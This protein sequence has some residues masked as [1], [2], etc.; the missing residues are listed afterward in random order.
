MIAPI[1][2]I[3]LFPCVIVR[4]IVPHCRR[5]GARRSTNPVGETLIERG[6]RLDPHV[7]IDP[8]ALATFGR[9]EARA[10]SGAGLPGAF[11][12]SLIGKGLGMRRLDRD[13]KNASEHDI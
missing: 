2:R 7:T 3:G 5:H 13:D 11:F 4:P 12:Y 9:N 8:G 10:I 6:S 1:E